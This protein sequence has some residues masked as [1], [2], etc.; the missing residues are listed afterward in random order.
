MIAAALLDPV[1]GAGYA[2]VGCQVKGN[3]S[4]NTGERIF[5]IPGQS[6]YSTTHITLFKGE[7]WFCSE[8]A[9]SEAGWRKSYQ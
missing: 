6:Y 3:I 5:H 7:R 1:V 9:A 2:L 8:Q 4:P